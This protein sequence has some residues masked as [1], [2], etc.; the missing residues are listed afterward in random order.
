VPGALATAAR[1]AV[2]PAKPAGSP[3]GL[4]AV[5]AV[6]QATGCRLTTGEPPGRGHHAVAPLWRLSRHRGEPWISAPSWWQHDRAATVHRRDR[7]GRCAGIGPLGDEVA[8]ERVA[9]CQPLATPASDGQGA[10]VRFARVRFAASRFARA[11]PPGRACG[12]GAQLRPQ[13][14]HRGAVAALASPRRALSGEGSVRGH[15]SNVIYPGQRPGR[16]LSFLPPEAEKA[17]SQA[18]SA[19]G[20]ARL[21]G[22]QDDMPAR[23]QGAE[24][25]KSR[26]PSGCC[27][28]R[29]EL[30]MEC[31]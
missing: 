17:W 5:A 21:H 3:R 27:E 10:P 1:K 7:R 15:N 31:L 22:G 14:G 16:V 12:S 29:P 30:P 28:A 2:R 4:G 19:H 8:A 6:T 26:L 24:R 11:R 13:P 20:V 18:R 23:P 25:P 9:R